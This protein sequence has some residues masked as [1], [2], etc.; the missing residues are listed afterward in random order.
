MIPDVQFL[1]FKCQLFKSSKHATLGRSVTQGVHVG[2]NDWKA[3]RANSGRAIAMF[4]L[5]RIVVIINRLVITLN[6][7]LQ[8]VIPSRLLFSLVP[9]LPQRHETLGIAAALQMRC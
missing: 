9:L 8:L 1:A 6:A 2:E 5:P 3:E 7:S 4:D